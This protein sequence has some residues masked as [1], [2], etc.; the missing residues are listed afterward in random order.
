M[1]VPPSDCGGMEPTER[2]RRPEMA[3]CE[4]HDSVFSGRKLRGSRRSHLVSCGFRVGDDSFHQVG[5]ISRGPENDPTC[6]WGGLFSANPECSL[7]LG[8]W[9]NNMVSVREVKYNTW[10]VLRHG[11]KDVETH[12]EETDQSRFPCDYSNLPRTSAFCRQ[13]AHPP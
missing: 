8:C 10:I 7:G 4:V 1:P 5:S 3:A 13:Y 11:S 2:N 12:D 9:D 6:G